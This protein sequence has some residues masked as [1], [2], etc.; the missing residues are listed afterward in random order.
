[1]TLAVASGLEVPENDEPTAELTD[2]LAE[3]DLIPAGARADVDRI[4][5]FEADGDSGEDIDADK[6]IGPARDLLSHARQAMA[7]AA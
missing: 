7:A 4:L 2:S 5:A 1:M 3:R 6:T